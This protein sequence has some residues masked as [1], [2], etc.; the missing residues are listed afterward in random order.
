[1]TAAGAPLSGLK[2]VR[3]GLVGC[4]AIARAHLEALRHLGI[5]V[6]AVCDTDRERA[7]RTASTLGV[8]GVYARTGELLQRERPDVL[9]V[10]TP[11][12]SHRETSI[13]ALEA[14]CDVLVEKPMAM[15]TCEADEMVDTARRCGRA[16]GVCHTMLFDPA[17]ARLREAVRAG[18]LGSVVAVETVQAIAGG[19]RDRYFTTGWV[20]QLPGGVAQE[21]APHH[22]YLQ[23]DLLGPIGVVGVLRREAARPDSPSF[24][25]WAL[26]EGR[27]GAGTTVISLSGRPR[28]TLIRVYGTEATAQVDVRGR[29]VL[30][31]RQD[32]IGGRARRALVGM[33]LGAALAGKAAAGA[34]ADVRRPWHRGH[35]RLIRSF[36]RARLEGVP[37]PVSGEDGRATVAVLDR[38]WDASGKAPAREPSPAT[39]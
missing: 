9:H 36:Y 7:A 33:G 14:G 12:Q 19:E 32:M 13:E 10:A 34:F 20:R 27:S 6:V 1:V 24:D 37:P 8:R 29:T 23:Q 28:R 11:P 26:F 22:V 30:T 15:D 18:R 16:L 2:R 4:G 39:G 3:A 17:V 38:L 21:L 5:E 31:A 35:W 25:F